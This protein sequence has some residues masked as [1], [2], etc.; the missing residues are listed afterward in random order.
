M[1]DEGRRL[2][3]VFPDG[4]TFGE[5]STRLVLPSECD[6]QLLAACRT[7]AGSSTS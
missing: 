2:E 6:R 4:N 5:I 3:G 7:A 1:T